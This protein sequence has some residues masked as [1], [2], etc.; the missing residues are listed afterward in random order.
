MIPPSQ[1][2]VNGQAGARPSALD[3]GLAYGD[4]VFRTLRVEAGVPLWWH[5]HL[6]KL[7]ADSRRLGLDCPPPETWE[8]D[9]ARLALAGG[10]VLRLTLTRGE[11]PRGYGPPPDP[12][13]TRVV[14]FWPGEP[15]PPAAGITVR[16]CG[17]RLGHQ[18]AL[19]G[20]KHLNR[21]ENVLARAEWRD[22]AIQEGILLDQDGH[23]VSGVTSN[24]FLWQGGC[25]RT[26]RLERCGVAGVARARLMGAAARAGYRVEEGDLALADLEAA[27]ELMFTNSLILLWRAA[28]LESRTWGAPV[29]SPELAELLRG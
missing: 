23:L 4:G 13:T 16:V 11:G 6:R 28:R 12:E 2:L 22:P 24:L 17:L 5:D 19:A 14:T 10:G 3:R 18:P 20:V 21:L 7:A 26:P 1:T 15:P 9:L 27:E 25:L 8:D 29:V